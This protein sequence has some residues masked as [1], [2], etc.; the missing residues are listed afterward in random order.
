MSR[1]TS[2]RDVMSR[3]IEPPTE[4]PVWLLG[5][6]RPSQ[7]YFLPAW[8]ICLAPLSLAETKAS[9][10]HCWRSCDW[11]HRIRSSSQAPS[12]NAQRWL[13]GTFL[14]P[15]CPITAPSQSHHLSCLHFWWRTPHQWSDRP[16]SVAD[17]SDS[18]S[19]SMFSQQ[20]HRQWGWL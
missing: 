14:I 6:P 13:L 16:S 3:V 7:L 4:L 8:C 17:S 15:L 1:H 2:Y 12:D 19:V 5:P 11:L 18:G 10:W 20:I 9:I